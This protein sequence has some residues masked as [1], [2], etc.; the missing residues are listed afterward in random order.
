[1]CCFVVDVVCWEQSWENDPFVGNDRFWLVD[2]Q[3]NTA[4]AVFQWATPPNLRFEFS[5]YLKIGISLS[6]TQ[7]APCI[8]LSWVSSSSSLLVRGWCCLH[9]ILQQPCPHFCAPCD[10]STCAHS[11][12]LHVFFILYPIFFPVGVN[13]QPILPKGREKQW[14][15]RIG[16]LY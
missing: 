2:L 1:M 16:L 11:S 15:S 9:E 12:N 6:Q 4:S 7:W 10:H 3:V 5:G 13:Q 8:V 14:S